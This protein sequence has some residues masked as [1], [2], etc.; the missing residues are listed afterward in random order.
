M[1][2]RSM[3]KSMRTRLFIV[4][5]I[6]A[7]ISVAVRAASPTVLF[8]DN[9][10]GYTSGSYYQNVNSQV[11]LSQNNGD[12]PV[13][14]STED[15]W[16]VTAPNQLVRLCS[17]TSMAYTTIAVNKSSSARFGQ[18]MVRLGVDTSPAMLVRLA[19]F[20]VSNP[21]FPTEWGASA[22]NAG[23]EIRWHFNGTLQ[24][25]SGGAINATSQT[26]SGIHTVTINY[27]LTAH[28]YDVWYNQTK[29][30]SG[31]SFGTN[32][33]SAGSIAIGGAYDGGG[34]AALD[35]WHWETCDSN[36]FT[37]YG[38]AITPPK[39]LFHD[40]ISSEPNGF[41]YQDI[42]PNVVI[43][44]DNGD[45]PV[46]ESKEDSWD[47]NSPNQLVRLCSGTSM[48]YT[49][50]AVNRHSTD[51]YGQVMVRLG[52]DT[53][54]A[55]LVRLGVFDVNNPS[56]PDEWGNSA[57][58]AGPEIRWHFNG[59]LQYGSNG[60]IT[61]TSQAFS[62]FHNVTINYDLQTHKYDAWYNQTEFLS[63][64]SFGTNINSAESIA[65]GG[66]WDGGGD[67]ALDY[68][69]W[70][71]SD[72]N[73]F[74]SYGAQIPVPTVAPTVLFWDDIAGYTTNAYY[75]NVNPEVVLSQNNGSN[76]TVLSTIGDLSVTAPNQLVNIASGTS[77]AYSTIAVNK[78]STARYG[79]VLVRMGYD[80][81]SPNFSL[82]RLGVFGVPNGTFAQDW[83]TTEGAN[84]GPDVR[85][86][87]VGLQ[88][89]SNGTMITTK[90]TTY[91]N[92][93]DV[94]I[95]YDLATNTYEVWYN[96]TRLVGPVAFASPLTAIESIA[97]G[98]A[99]ISGYSGSAALDSW[100]WQVSDTTP[101][102]SYGVQIP[103]PL[104]WYADAPTG[105]DTFSQTPLTESPAHYFSCVQPY[106]S[107]GT[108]PCVIQAHPGLLDYMDDADSN[109]LNVV[110]NLGDVSI[111]WP[112]AVI[113]LGAEVNY[114]KDKPALTGFYNFDE[115]DIRGCYAAEMEGRYA[116]IKALRPDLPVSMVFYYHMAELPSLNHGS[117]ADW[118]AGT[119]VV[120][121]EA[122]QTWRVPGIYNDVQTT[123]AAGKKFVVCPNAYDILATPENFRYEALGA[124]AMGA[125]GIMPFI[126]EGLG[127]EPNRAT[128]VYPTTDI[129][130]Q[131]F[132]VLVKGPKT[133]L[134]ASTTL[135][136]GNYYIAGDSKDAMLV[137]V[138]HGS[139]QNNVYLT[140]S[141]L[142]SYV[143]SA[144]VV[145][146]SRSVTL[147]NNWPNIT[148]YDNFGVE[149]VHIY[150]F[151]IP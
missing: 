23:P 53:N 94:T 37:S 25:G 13:V 20:S 131:I 84:V 75:Q 100:Q 6:L 72:S 80:Y 52:V 64:V 149:A 46:V 39:I 15:A 128:V 134:T 107:Y 147:T 4:V 145:G 143:S 99:C 91:S 65:I 57:S 18:I 17:V 26:F 87:W 118:L 68:W 74:T 35:Y 97:L 5:L 51:R 14:E 63:G 136:N 73:A 105:L 111:D 114:V 112:D 150:K 127:S 44:Q 121:F 36:A 140:V 92:L 19:L 30:L 89:G 7:A 62:G 138:N 11:V 81:I 148:F 146:E 141:G 47:V 45:H 29:F 54:P 48:K 1:K 9:I 96:E 55:M 115:P 33:N 119:D 133:Y 98:G 32:I 31:V 77:Y 86:S 110:I 151:H 78:H 27:D 71:T 88:Y 106:S 83:E 120:L 16:S 108:D 38:I 69:H 8:Y 144:T 142:A 28:T 59:T 61:S 109:G 102:D 21:Q 129:Y 82:V 93:H 117:I 66:A 135:S 124:I 50:L 67:A 40:N 79:Q 122:Y 49:T 56:F 34:D 137:V 58:H 12:H 101:F 24:Y 123:H 2:G 85:W 103:V 139:T 10:A 3:S 41:F 43:S 76:P 42:N 95:N 113:R 90:Q 130:H 22:A 126:F 132:P 116:P 125:D 60:A 70:E 104:S